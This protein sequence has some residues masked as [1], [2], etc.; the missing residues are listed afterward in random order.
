MVQDLKRQDAQVTFGQL[1]KNPQY[2]KQLKV[3][4]E[5]AEKKID[6]NLAQTHVDDNTKYTAA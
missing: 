3:E 1:L 4:I 2:L 6:I 5:K